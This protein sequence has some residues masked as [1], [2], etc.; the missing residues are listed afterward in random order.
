M[1]RYPSA[2]M[3][4][5]ALPLA[6]PHMKAALKLAWMALEDE[7]QRAAI[8]VAY[9]NLANFQDGLGDKAVNI[10]LSADA[11]P[12]EVATTLGAA[13]PWM[14]KSMEEMKSLKV[15]LDAFKRSQETH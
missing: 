6:K 9:L 3:D 10:M 8:E 11:Y 4:S 15:E 5:K 7:H 14:N 2:I 1:E 12:G 13:L